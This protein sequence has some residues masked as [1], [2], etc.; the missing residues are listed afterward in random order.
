MLCSVDWQLA[1]DVSGQPIGAIFKKTL[2]DWTARFPETSVTYCQS[3]LRNVPGDRCGGSLKSH[4]I[5]S[6]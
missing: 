1:A 4:T 6:S 2:E 3:T 5:N